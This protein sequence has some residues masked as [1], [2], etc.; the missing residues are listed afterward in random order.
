MIRRLEEQ[1]PG[2]GVGESRVARGEPAASDG[3]RFRP[4]LHTFAGPL[5]LLLYLIH[6][7]EVDI[8][9]IPIAMILD[10]Y[11]DHVRML[12]ESR[13]VDLGNAG[14]FLVMATRLMEIKSRMLL[15]STAELGDDEPLEEEIDDPRI[16]LVEQ[17]LEYREIKERALLLQEA[18]D[19]RQS[20]FDRQQHLTAE[21]TEQK[22]D[23]GEASIYDLCGAFQRVLDDLRERREE[24]Q[25]VEV[26][27]I[28]IEEVIRAVVATLESRGAEPLR[29]QELFTPE[30][31]LSIIITYFLAVLEMARLRVVRLEQRAPCEDLL[32]TLRELP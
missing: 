25:V 30:M 18:H 1:E 15:P 12:E 31:P 5:D 21:D 17:L 27:D 3:A 28:P 6:R 9:D 23:V 24:I 22:L 26:E 20:R 29:F 8:F 13:A 10:Q 4:E 11:L 32:L 19:L 7:N 16:S 2:H 14:E